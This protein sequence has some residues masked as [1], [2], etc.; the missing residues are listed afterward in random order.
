MIGFLPGLAVRLIILAG[1]AYPAGTG[2]A[3]LAAA[4]LDVLAMTF[5]V[6]QPAGTDWEGRRE[7]AA[8][9]IAKEKPDF[10]GTQE[11]VAAQRDFLGARN[12]GY[13]WFGVGR[14]G[15]DNGEGS[16]IFYRS[17]RFRV[18]SLRSGNFW[19]SNTPGVPSR[20]GGSYNRLCTYARLIEK[21]TGRGLYVFNAHF[22][23]PDQTDYR[24]ASA[25]M[26]AKAVTERAVAADP[27]V[28]T[29]DFN[30]PETDTVTHWYKHG[31][32]N[33]FRLR[34]SYRDF[35][36]NGAVTTGFGVKL[37][38]IY[39]PDA[40]GY[41]TTKA[42]VITDPA[43]A[44]DHMPT[45]SAL[46]ITAGDPVQVRAGS[47]GQSARAATPELPDRFRADGRKEGIPS[48]QVWQ[49]GRQDLTAAP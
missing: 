37:D 27:V 43:G 15:G 3:R 7:R 11:A 30:S 6:Q 35:D 25:R 12:P 44:S 24:L 28:V 49:A 9:I 40:P 19:L 39:V 20:L 10:L 18:D 29:G 22:Y 21:S 5:N 16:W 26:L 46:R 42:W 34:D 36:P 2:A 13:A 38:Y 17:D 47:G 4:P 23:M 14:D 1:L 48:R 31:T 45:A 32:D 41:A 33:P 8:S